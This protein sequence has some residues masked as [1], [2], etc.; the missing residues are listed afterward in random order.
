MIDKRRTE[1]KSGAGEP[2]ARTERW[3]EHRIA[4][5]A[6]FVDAA[7]RALDKIGAEATL[8]DICDEA[9]AKKP[10]LYRFFEDKVDLY[11]AIGDRVVQ[12]L[13]GRLIGRV[14]LVQDSARE[15]IRGCASEYSAVVIEHPNV[16]RF[17]VQG[18]FT[19]NPEQA[20][21]SRE[22]GRNYA[23]LV[24]GMAASALDRRHVDRR[25][26]EFTVIAIFG[27]VATS[28]DWWLAINEAT[29]ENPISND[30]FVNQLTAIIVGIAESTLSGNGINVDSD[31]PLNAAIG[32]V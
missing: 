22:V 27:A 1:S 3:R 31:Q 24:A 11:N 23:A 18:H 32:V 26:A 6:E 15:I 20:E 2:D 4:V 19:Q 12:T 17:M 8:H 28:T 30:V 14:N 10:K 25:L 29:P 9:G 21:R 13:W 5:R 7:Y 16:F